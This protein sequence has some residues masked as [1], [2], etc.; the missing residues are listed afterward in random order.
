MSMTVKDILSKSFPA[1][2]AAAK[3]VVLREDSSLKP[4]FR[5]VPNKPT[6]H[7]A[8]KLTATMY[9]TATADGKQK[10]GKPRHYKATVVGLDNK[11]KLSEGPVKV[12]CDCDYFTFT[13][14]V[15]LTRKGASAIR[16]SNGAPP[17]QTNP[18]MVPTPCKH[19]HK[20]LSLI[21]KR[22]V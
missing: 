8:P 22:R 4:T 18:K 20:L 21:V 5:N 1:V 3:Y 13:C 6:E 9:S 12:T 16:N 17:V 15:A 19:L 7:G 2:Q 14:E 11:Q 10:P